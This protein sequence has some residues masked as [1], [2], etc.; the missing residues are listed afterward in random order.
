MN[1]IAILSDFGDEDYYVPAMKA[2]IL[3]INRDV[4]IVD[5]T[6]KVNKWDILDGAFKL[7]LV[8]PYLPKGTIILAVVDPGVGTGRYPIV[9]KTNNYV[10]VGPDNGLMYL[11]AEKDG[12]QEIRRIENNSYTLGD[13]TTFDGRDVF[14]PVA[15]YISK[16]V[17]L[18]LIG[19]RLTDIKKI[20]LP[21][22]KLSEDKI[23]AKALHID[24]FGNIIL[25]ISCKEFFAWIR[26]ASSVQIVIGEEVFD[27]KFSK[28][29][30]E[31]GE[32]YGVLCGG[33]GFIEIAMYRESAAKKL[34]INELDD[35]IIIRQ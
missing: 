32:S 19:R 25:N 3:S 30:E 34:G 21:K 20:E 28:S 4:E 6:H 33:T 17:P 16:G 9:I 23:E 11:A 8:T 5:I 35:L 7:L 22:P 15:A 14:A 10:F 24:Y 27:A 12:I 18:G 13:R 2:V 29:Y 26:D 1:I 31:L